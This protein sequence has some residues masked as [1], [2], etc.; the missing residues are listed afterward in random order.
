MVDRKEEVLGVEVVEIQFSS[1]KFSNYGTSNIVSNGI[2]SRIGAPEIAAGS[3]TV[4][5]APTSNPAIPEKFPNRGEYTRRH[6]PLELVE[7]AVNLVCQ[8]GRGDVEVPSLH[9]VPDA[10]FEVG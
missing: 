7:S 6:Q 10:V 4:L 3:G 2:L 1:G 5:K 8:S 9:L